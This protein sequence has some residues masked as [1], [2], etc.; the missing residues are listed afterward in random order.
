MLKHPSTSSNT[1]T[2]CLGPP[3][4]HRLPAAANMGLRSFRSPTPASART[5]QQAFA[6]EQGTSISTV[7]FHS[8]PWTVIGSRL[9][10]YHVLCL[11]WKA[12]GDHCRRHDA[13]LW[14]TLAIPQ[15][16]IISYN[17]PASKLS[18]GALYHPSKVIHQ[19]F[20]AIWFRSARPSSPWKLWLGEHCG[21]EMHRT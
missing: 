13:L 16:M 3:H 4:G 11:V 19:T 17:I 5:R 14:Q 18:G 10:F 15:N 8:C 20:S 12:C 21:L 9:V 7:Q 6:F 2:L 1:W